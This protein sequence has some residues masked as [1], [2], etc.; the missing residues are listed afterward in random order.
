[1]LWRL[2]R[3][4]LAPHR[5]AIWTIVVLQLG[6]AIANLYLPHLN[7]SIIDD[8]VAKGDTGYI[9]SSGGVMLA[10]SLVQIAASVYA[11][12]LAARSSMAFGRDTRARVFHQV[13]QFSAREVAQFGA[14]TLISRS[15]NDVQQIQMLVF[16]ALALMVGPRP[17]LRR[18]DVEMQVAIAQMAEG[19]D[20]ERPQC[21]DLRPRLAQKAGD[22]RQGQ[23]DVVA[24]HRTNAPVRLRYRLADRPKLIGLRA[25]GDHHGPRLHDMRHRFATNTLVNWYRSNQDPQR[26][27]PI[28]SAY[29]GHVHVEDT[30]WYLNGCPE[31]MSEAMRRVEHLWETRP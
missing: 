24:G 7:A 29:L 23:R 14:P 20:P 6:S 10:V 1:M 13:G 16:M 2:I 11:V 15:T 26:L 19:A 12:Y 3:S 22:R 4:G 31:L 28:L 21:R 18:K 5:G 27:L 25:D 30:Q 17:A 9:L 8:G